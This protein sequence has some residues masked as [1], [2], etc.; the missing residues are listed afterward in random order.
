MSSEGKAGF[1]SVTESKLHPQL[2]RT[3]LQ[4]VS[5]NTCP[6][7]TKIQDTLKPKTV[8]MDTVYHGQ[9]VT[10]EY[11]LVIQVFLNIR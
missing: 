6:D 4:H 8:F 3:N 1:I 7:L 10:I 5:E 2:N 11:I 9:F